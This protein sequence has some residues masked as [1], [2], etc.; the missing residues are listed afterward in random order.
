[1]TTTDIQEGKVYKLK[2]QR[3]G[4]LRMQVTNV[5]HMAD[6][7]TWITGILHHDVQGMT[8]EWYEGESMQIRASLITEVQE[9]N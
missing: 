6:G 5:T 3:K 1:M 7:T 2:H 4:W 9:V 8:T